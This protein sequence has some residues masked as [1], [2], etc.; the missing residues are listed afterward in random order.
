MAAVAF[1]VFR[2]LAVPGEVLVPEGLAEHVDHG[3]GL[4]AT[5][6]AT[7]FAHLFPFGDD[8]GSSGDVVFTHVLDFLLETVQRESEAFGDV[9][10][11]EMAG[12]GIG[13]DGFCAVVTGHDD[14]AFSVADVEYIIVSGVAVG[15]DAGE[16]KLDVSVFLADSS[17][18]QELGTH[19][20]CL[21][22]VDWASQQVAQSKG[23]KA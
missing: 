13:E 22:L 17:G 4:T 23:D 9:A 5:V 12:G 19:F 16:L 21:L 8:V 1:G 20:L 18:A 2:A 15:G 14:E 6:E 3:T 11:V 7:R 10:R